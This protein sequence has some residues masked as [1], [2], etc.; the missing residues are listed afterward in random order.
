MGDHCDRSPKLL[1]YTIFVLSFDATKQSHPEFFGQL[2]YLI[3]EPISDATGVLGA[4]ALKIKAMKIGWKWV[5]CSL[6]MSWDRHEWPL[7]YEIED[8]NTYT[9]E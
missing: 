6:S 7:P 4:C 5:M 8:N 1:S 9:T 2:N 3:D